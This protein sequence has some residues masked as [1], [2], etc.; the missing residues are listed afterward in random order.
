[1]MAMRAADRT[2]PIG[3][4]KIFRDQTQARAAEQALETS[5]AELVQALVENRRARAEAEAANRAKDRF[6]AIL[7]HELR[8]PLTPVVMALHALER[9]P[10]LPQA[11]RGTSR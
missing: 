5:R 4:L 3:L 2:H 1:M 9:S 7:S 10:E 8:T 11:L 6:L